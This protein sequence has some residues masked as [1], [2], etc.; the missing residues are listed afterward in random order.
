MDPAT[1]MALSIAGTGVSAL[2]QISSANAA[3]ENAA[4]QAAVAN[5][6]QIIANQ[7]AQYAAQA[8]QAAVTRQQLIE[9]D[10]VGGLI[11]AMG[12]SGID[13]N[14]GSAARVRK[15]AGDIGQ[16]DVENKGQEA[17]LR[18]YGFRTQATNYEAQSKLYQQEADQAP[19]AGL[20][21]AGGT[22]L[23]GLGTVGTRYSL[24]QQA[25]T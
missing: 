7:N 10:K 21:S 9:R 17:A 16:L 15:S 25:A 3:S 24:W 13:P 23:N 11:A 1:A 2:G 6:N 4:Y 22:L 18:V 14:T 5:N 12:A 20:I 8:G 19:L